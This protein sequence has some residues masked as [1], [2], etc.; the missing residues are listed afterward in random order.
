MSMPSIPTDSD[1]ATPPRRVRDL[2]TPPGW[3]LLGQLPRFDPPR[4]HLHFEAWA[5]E[6]G[7]P[8][9]LQLGP[10]M[11][12]VVWDDFA[13]LQQVN[14]ERP[15]GY[16]RARP[17]QPTFAEMGIN[18]LFSIEGEAWHP[19][20]RL[21][22]QA[23][24][25]THFRGWFATMADITCRL[26]RRWSRAAEHG[27]V[28]EMTDELKRY[29]VD[30]TCALAFGE[31]PNTLETES[32]R[33]QQQLEVIFPMVMKRSLLPLRY[34]NWLKLPEDR[35]L[36]RALA[37]VHA[38]AR[39]RIAN[40]RARLR[41]ADGEAP[42]NALEALLMNQQEQGLSE[43]DIVANVI[44]LLLAG[45]DTTSNSLAWTM[46][47]LAA[48]RPLQQ[49]MHERALAKLG[50]SEVCPSH[51]CLHGLDDFEPLALEALRL[52][53]VVPFV[54]FTA[55]RDT[56]L[57][58]VALP[59]GTMMFFLNRP[60]MLDPANFDHP[61]RYDP[62]RWRRERDAPGSVHESRAFV[63]FGAGPRVCP[64]RHLATLEM[65][66]VLSMLLRHFEVE[67]ACDPASIEEVSAFT[68]MPSRMPVRLHR[69]KGRSAAA[70]EAAAEHR[71]PASAEAG[72][73]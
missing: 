21:I 25:A 19:Q 43:Q 18:G 48:N 72:T 56:V 58:G 65:R 62:A 9:R 63:Q 28:L 59:A 55:I 20:R 10:G 12:F 68:M 32:N 3:P 42:R 41:E 37:E 50:D 57:D 64:G 34:W 44:T 73:A 24:N 8:Y 51:E 47:Y 45:E 36:D 4:A 13:L 30:V 60:A 26:Y 67:L 14:R 69:R 70:D 71:E 53:P 11:Q 27:E 17:L 29:T 33:I 52:R 7:T 22:M 31:D 6:L 38:Y 54:S 1:S 40:A 15:H 35:R 16:T 49:R 66:L 46:L 23:L 61:E 39:A 5:R 2:P